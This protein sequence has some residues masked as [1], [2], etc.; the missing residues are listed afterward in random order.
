MR[1]DLNIKQL[2]PIPDGKEDPNNHVLDHPHVFLD[3]I[4]R[5]AQESEIIRL[6][7]HI[8]EGKP[9]LTFPVQNKQVMI[10]DKRDL[11]TS[12]LTWADQVLC[13]TNRNKINLNQQMRQAYGFLPEVQLGDKIINTHHEWEICSN[14]E[15]PL[16]NG[17]IG[18]ITQLE[19]QD[20]E[21]P[22]WIRNE[23]LTVPVLVATISGDEEG[24]EFT[25]LP[26]DY[27]EIMTGQPS[28]S[29]KEEYIITKRLEMAT[30]LHANFGYAITV[31]K[32]QGS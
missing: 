29:G 15:T 2:P 9:L 10:F 11:N 4:M 20:W 21:Y 19:R 12:M 6:S 5:Q 27:T 3:E 30:P 13:A 25:L 7:M 22:Y 24:E 8:R 17:V 18:K 28:L 26:F 1:A 32:A 31:W 16:T 23:K 14:H